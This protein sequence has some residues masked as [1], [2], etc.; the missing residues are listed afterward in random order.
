MANERT[1]HNASRQTWYKTDQKIIP[2]IENKASSLTV[3][4][5]YDYSFVFLTLEK[6]ISKSNYARLAAIG[7]KVIPQLPESQYKM[8]VETTFKTY[9]ERSR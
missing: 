6:H 8:F 5:L 7:E 2:V 4:E 3:E 9:K 1:G